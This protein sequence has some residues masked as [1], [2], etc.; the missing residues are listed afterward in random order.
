VAVAIPAY[1][2][3]PTCWA[4]AIRPLTSSNSRS[5]ATDIWSRSVLEMAHVGAW[6]ADRATRHG[7]HLCAT[8]EMPSRR[9]HQMYDTSPAVKTSDPRHSPRSAGSAVGGFR[10]WAEYSGRRASSQHPHYPLR[11]RSVVVD[12]KVSGAAGGPPTRHPP[13]RSA[14]KYSARIGAL[15]SPRGVSA[16]EWRLGALVSPR[17]RGAVQPA[18]GRQDPLGLLEILVL[19]RV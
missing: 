13:P 12:P 3:T 7:V 9:D 10:T 16:S 8:S 6:L 17:E 5:S 4:R 18:S 19:E 14:W 11:E 2:S 15:R 1:V